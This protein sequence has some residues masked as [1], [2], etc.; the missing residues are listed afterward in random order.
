MTAEP[1]FA[2]CTCRRLFN[3]GSA[4]RAGLKTM[5]ELSKSKNDLLP[6]PACSSGVDNKRNERQR[7]L[8]NE[9]CMLQR[10][11]PGSSLDEATT[12][13]RANLV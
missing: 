11:A 8:L 12:P 5:R 9:A 3:L 6:L 7:A 10:L 1:F 13:A 2:T 4:K